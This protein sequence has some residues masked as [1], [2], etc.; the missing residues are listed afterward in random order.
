MPYQLHSS[1]L[2]GELLLILLD[3]EDEEDEELD[4][5]L[6]IELEEELL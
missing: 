2:A 6:E 5:E 1:P 3:E 4:K